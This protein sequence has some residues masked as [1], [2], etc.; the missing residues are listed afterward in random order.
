EPPCGDGFGARVEPYGLLSVRVLVA[1][2]RSA[3]SREREKRQGNRDR[4]VD[5]NLAHVDFSLKLAGGVAA[6]GK[7]RGAISV[8]VVVDDL[9]GFLDC[10]G[11]KAQENRSKDFLLVDLHV[12]SDFVEHRWSYEVSFFES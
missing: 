12:G 9:D 5:A 8:R 2:E 6:R 11:A 1:K 10:F 7:D 3:P 4:N